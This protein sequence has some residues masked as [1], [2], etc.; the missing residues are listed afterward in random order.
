MFDTFHFAPTASCPCSAPGIPGHVFG[1]PL[2]VWGA[3][4]RSLPKSVLRLHEKRFATFPRDAAAAAASD[5]HRHVANSAADLGRSRRAAGI[6]EARLRRGEKR[7]KG[8]TCGQRRDYPIPAEDSE[9][10]V[11]MLRFSQ[12]KQLHG[13]AAICPC[14]LYTFP[15]LP[16]KK[17]KLVTSHH[18][19]PST[20][21]KE[22]KHEKNK[23]NRKRDER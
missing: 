15:V 1:L 20:L 10:Y 9:S 16:K 19:I 3:A 22:M 18:T 6:A 11:P 23:I 21:R 5:H 14:R 8:L 2:F 7:H 4:A 17:K 13:Q 12:G